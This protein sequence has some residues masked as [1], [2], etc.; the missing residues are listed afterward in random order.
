[1]AGLKNYRG[2]LALSFS[3]LATKWY[4]MNLMS[5]AFQAETAVY[6]SISSVPDDIPVERKPAPI[7]KLEIS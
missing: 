3:P 7:R 5:S 1:M 4:H 6:L 2:A